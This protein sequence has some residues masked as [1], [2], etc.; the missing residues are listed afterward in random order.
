MKH[1]KRLILI[2]TFTLCS[3]ILVSCVDDKEIALNSI[4]EY[5]ENIKDANYKEAYDMLGEISINNISFQDFEECYRLYNH[6]IEDIELEVE[7]IEENENSTSFFIIKKTKTKGSK[8]DSTVEESYNLEVLKNTKENKIEVMDKFI[9]DSGRAYLYG[10]FKEGLSKDG[11]LSRAV[12]Y[13]EKLIENNMNDPSSY[14]ILAQI[15]SYHEEYDNALENIDKAIDL[16]ENEPSSK[17]GLLYSQKG[18]IM[19]ETGNYDESVKLLEKALELNPELK[20]AKK[21]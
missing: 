3:L 10:A 8:E 11:S 5:E 13:A 6:Y 20:S 15:Y 19:Y 1:I 17:I 16:S 14:E 7:R 12:K 2:L 4:I 21:D 18:G 9:K